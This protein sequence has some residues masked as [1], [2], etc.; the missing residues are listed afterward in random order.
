MASEHRHDAY[1]GEIEDIARRGGV[2]HP[3][4]LAQV[5]ATLMLCDYAETI[6][7]SLE[8]LADQHGHR[9]PHELARAADGSLWVHDHVG[10]LRYPVDTTIAH[11][12]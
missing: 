5:L 2:N 12:I 11:T 3:V 10:G 4:G 6:A 1:R 9:C 7:G 8:R